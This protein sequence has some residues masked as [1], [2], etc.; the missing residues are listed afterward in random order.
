MEL[1]LSEIKKEISL[2]F[3]QF[4]DTNSIEPLEDIIGQGRA[5]KA[6]EFGLIVNKKG[7]N[8]Y[9][10][11]QTGTGKTSYALERISKLALSRNTPNDWVYIYNFSTPDEPLSVSLPKGVAKEFKKDMDEFIEA[12]LNELPKV[13]NSEEY[14]NDKNVILNEFQDIKT[15]MFDKL[16]QEAKEFEFE[17]KFTPSGV[18]FLP[19]LN[20]KT[21]TENEYSNLEKSLREDIEKKLKI[22][23]QNAVD[24]L[25]KIKIIEKQTREKIKDLQ[26][27]I[28]IFTLGH[29]INEIRN[30]YKDISKINTFLDN[31]TNDIV[32]NLELFFE[33]EEEEQNPYQTFFN[34]KKISFSPVDKYK[35]NIIVDNSDIIG[36]PVIYEPNPTYYNLIGK[37][38]Y[39]NEYGVYLIT[40]FSKIKPGALHKANGGYLILQA[41]DLLSNPQSWEVLKRVLKNGYVQIEN[42]R[43]VFG[44]LPT[45]S[46]KPEPIPIDIKVILI[47]N[48]YIYNLLYELDEDFKKLFKIKVDFDT[49]MNLNQENILKM[50]QFISSFCKRENTIPFTKNAIQKVLEYSMRLTENQNKLS[51]K[52]NEIVEILSESITWAEIDNQQKVYDIHVIKAIREKEYRSSKYEEKISELINNK[53]IMVDVDGY[54]VG[55]INGLAIISD[56]DYSFGKPSRITVTTSVGKN[57]II[58]IEREVQMSGKTHSKGVL[59]ISGFFTERY[60]Q[61]MPLTLNATICFEQLYSGID[62]DS[63]SAAEL[64]ALLSSLSGIPIYQGIAVTGSINQKGEIQAV[65]GVTKKIEGF[66]Y[67]CKQLGLNGR[68]GVIIPTSNIKN[69]TLND[70]VIGSIKNNLFHIWAVSTIDQAIE[71][72][73]GVKSGEK[74]TQNE[75]PVGTINYLVVHK[76]KKYYSIYE[77]ENKEEH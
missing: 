60:A 42:M 37:I 31:I 30:K 68:Q 28:A 36:A 34:T 6:F 69:L 8:L 15:E 14:E 25:K 40:D 20:G 49:E 19:I 5:K 64:C 51:T 50:I 52:F 27:N 39:E 62:G 43:D 57:G 55:Q 77:K 54:N 46:L 72:L 66:Y 13:F 18:Y 65:G 7:Y 12:I 70:E 35:V 10:C 33:K 23:Q 32:N 1:K 61:D 67:T 58:N 63:A 21:L 29:Y 47:G 76:L 2:D 45:S 41:K 75:Y 16:A 24:V 71:I 56:G 26:R 9:L 22:L 11:G 74:N 48:E 17:I 44:L 53:I 73:T 4:E 59:I 38:E 3:M